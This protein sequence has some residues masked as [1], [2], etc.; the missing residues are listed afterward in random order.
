MVMARGAGGSQQG[1]SGAAGA[2]PAPCQAPEHLLAAGS[3]RGAYKERCG[4]LER[5][6]RQSSFVLI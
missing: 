5:R 1:S 2:A 6:N 4:G 3:G